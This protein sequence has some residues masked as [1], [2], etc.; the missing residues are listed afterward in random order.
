M[1]WWWR[2]SRAQASTVGLGT[3]PGRQGQLGE[4]SAG[5]AAGREGPPLPPGQ[6][7]GLGRETGQADLR[8]ARCSGLWFFLWEHSGHPALVLLPGGQSCGAHS[9]RGE[10]GL[11][12]VA[13]AH[14]SGCALLT[15]DRCWAAGP[16][17]D[18]SVRVLAVTAKPM[19]T[20]TVSSKP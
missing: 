5:Q 3:E 14:G 18:A 4:G 6:E 10:A 9:G 7:L 19:R 2:W 17:R 12:W 11:G 8:A 15:V 1:M 20:T 13:A 16:L